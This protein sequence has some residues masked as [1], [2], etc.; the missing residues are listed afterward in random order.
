M[1]P[2]EH[3]LKGSDDMSA[4]DTSV[5]IE[6]FEV[7]HDRLYAMHY[8]PWWWALWATLAKYW[9][10]VNTQENLPFPWTHIDL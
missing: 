7:P 9:S 10:V 3:M 6:L 4:H 8:M 5:S 1:S 2:A